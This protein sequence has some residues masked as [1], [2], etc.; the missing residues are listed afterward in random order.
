MNGTQR[1]PSPPYVEVSKEIDGQTYTAGFYPGF[2]RVIT[3][4]GQTLYNQ[5]DK[6]YGLL[7]YVL[8]P[9]TKEPASSSLLALSSTKGYRVT[10]QLDDAAH[11]LDHLEVVVRD[12][13]GGVTGMSSDGGAGGDH[14][15]VDNTPVLCPPM[16]G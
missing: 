16:C 3:V 8:P 7:P 4:N 12:P 11:V 14:W 15:G 5:E 10:L 1:E 6:E 2:A 13:R 9:D